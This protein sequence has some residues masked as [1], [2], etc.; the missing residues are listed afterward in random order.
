M[1]DDD[2]AARRAAARAAP[3]LQFKHDP[4]LPITGQREAILKALAER[5][6]L[7][8]A[9][10]TGSG[11][12]TQLPQY[13]LELGRG[14]T[15]LIAHTQ[16]R[17]L[18]ARALASRLAEELG[19]SLVRSVGFRVRF[20]DQ[21]SAATRLVLMTDGLLLAALTSDPLLQRYDTVIVDE[22]H[23]RTLNVDLL[24]GVLKRLLPRRPDLKVIVTSATLDVE[25]ISRF[26]D[27]APII[28]VSGR[29][30]P[31][32]VRYR[33][34]PD[35]EE[36]PDLGQ[37]VLEAYREIAAEPG[38]IGS[39]DVL[40][41]LPGE[42]E[43]RDVG[44]LLRREA[45]GAEVLELYS[46]LS[47]EQ[48]SKI[49]QRGSRRRIVLATNVAETSLTV[50][51]IRAVI[52]SGVARI[53][54]YSPR[55]RLQRLPIEPVSRAS[56]DQRK[57]RCGRLGP[58]LCLRLYTEEDFAERGAFTEPEVL[59]TNLAALL[60][61]LAADGLGEAEHF[62]FI[63]APD[64]RA[65]SDGYRLLQEL[66]ALDAERR[67]TRRGRAM[68][69][70]PL[71]PR[72]ARAL[73]ESKRFRAESE[74]LAIVAGLSV[75]DVRI[76]ASPAGAAVRGTAEDPRQSVA[77]EDSKSEFSALVKVWKAY[78]KAR[79]GPR[80]EL[81]RWCKERQFSLLRL[82]EWDDVYAQVADRAADIGIVAQ[83][84]AASYTGVH[85]SLLAGFCT[86]VGARGEEG[87]YLGT[88]GVHF[89]IFP[90]S[91]L[92]RRR[93]RW[94]MAANIVETSRVFARRVA[95]IEPQWIESAASHLLKREYLEPD[96]DEERE[97]VTARERVSFLGLTLSA[98]R[99][100]NY[101]P[102]APEES[103]LIFARE[104]LVYGRLHRRPDWLLANDAAI[105]GAQRMEER[106]RARDLLQGAEAFV[107]FYNGVLPRQVSSGAGLEYFT[108]NLSP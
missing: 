74:L 12:S 2:A 76:A 24:L 69:R 56:A 20:A 18:A 5:Q 16:P 11:K 71:D 29:N 45:V 65:L 77:F 107:E 9:G 63:D 82:S 87:V 83:R 37:A 14:T 75:P 34:A 4:E 42:R 67:I 49:F 79:E 15:G 86:M 47:W 17:R 51:G 40:V 13:C 95:E 100:V 19:Q 70:L 6:V 102:L 21:V 8:V 22:A 41:F 39:G 80:R 50:P 81:R 54:R 27:G 108:R 90:G 94:V 48:Q 33:E 104:A 58:G 97:A 25:R 64:A 32:E 66:E 7:I 60:L 55:S 101:G 28:T 88:R 61:R 91:P 99:L 96:W 72:L 10:D 59:R 57:G 93:P 98:N 52:D 36:D 103:R 92:V 3:Q 26:F 89:H 1:I 106:L 62:P 46:R 30:H 85:R 31:I 78:R 44:E 35:D 43:I 53:S 105:R 73:L 68:A 84:Q 23:E 38:Q